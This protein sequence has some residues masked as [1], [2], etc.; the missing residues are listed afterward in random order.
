MFGLLLLVVGI[1]MTIYG[2]VRINSI[3]SIMRQVDSLEDPQNAMRGLDN[4]LSSIK[5]VIYWGI[6]LMAVGLFL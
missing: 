1:F 5:S 2:S 3:M 4:E 6:G